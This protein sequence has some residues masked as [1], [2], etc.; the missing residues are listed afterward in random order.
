MRKW[1]IVLCKFFKRSKIKEW[2]FCQKSWG[3]KIELN[4]LWWVSIQMVEK[5]EV[6]VQQRELI[7]QKAWEIIAHL[8]NHS[9]C[10]KFSVRCIVYIWG[11]KEMILGIMMEVIVWRVLHTTLKFDYTGNK[12]LKYFKQECDKQICILEVIFM[13]YEE[14]IRWFKTGKSRRFQGGGGAGDLKLVLSQEFS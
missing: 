12:I 5:E 7:C 8:G 2:L 13:E 1:N 6:A 4:H 11:R 9:V 3:D 10:H 14:W